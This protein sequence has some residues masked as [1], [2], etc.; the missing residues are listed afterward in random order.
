MTTAYPSDRALKASP[1]IQP[2]LGRTAAA[3]SE[4]GTPLT[5]T[6]FGTADEIP[7]DQWARLAE[8]CGPLWRRPFFLAMERGNIGPQ[9]W[10][11]IAV[12]RGNQIVAILPV[13]HFRRLDLAEALGEPIRRWLLAA[14]RLLPNVGL[15]NA[16]FAGNL[17]GQGD[18]LVDRTEEIG[19]LYE[20]LSCAFGKLA[21]Q[22]GARWLVWKD[23][24][25]AAAPVLVVERHGFF[26]LPALPDTAIRLESPTLDE[27][28]AALP[29]KPRRNTRAKMRKFT[30][31]EGTRLDVIDSLEDVV[32][33]LDRFHE[34][35][36]RVLERADFRLDR[37][38]PAF[39]RELAGGGTGARFVVARVGTDVVGFL[40]MVMDER[41]AVALR[42]G[43]DY[44]R[45]GSIAAYH[46]VHYRGMQL[47][48][49]TGCETLELLQTAYEAKQELGAALIP[50][51]HLVRHTNPVANRALARLLP[52]LMPGPFTDGTPRL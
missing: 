6:T 52:P 24:T 34:L 27:F 36:T 18:A 13:S 8:G 49:A 46:N 48:L 28:L 42:V 37:L 23:H 47:A 43:L 3:R 19:E 16:L 26:Q 32:P 14:R 10:I 50:L 9:A 1:E 35:Y 31:A 21:R 12:A 33:L 5:V 2:P 40:V 30:Q 29:A 39:F 41:T 20:L 4:V 51:V 15:V 25:K 45:A 38:T 7:A 11:Y 17:L 44:E 22:Q